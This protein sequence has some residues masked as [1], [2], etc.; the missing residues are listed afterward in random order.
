MGRFPNFHTPKL[1][2]TKIY[3][4]DA[5]EVGTQE[6]TNKQVRSIK[7][8]KCVYVVGQIEFQAKL[9]L[10]LACNIYTVYPAKGSFKRY[11]TLPRGEGVSKV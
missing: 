6:T 11:V 8:L 3:R 7:V 1:K 9:S 10:N 5:A 4:S 2:F